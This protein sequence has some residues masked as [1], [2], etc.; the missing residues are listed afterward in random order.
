[1]NAIR[2]STNTAN[3]NERTYQGMQVLKT[4]YKVSLCEMGDRGWGWGRAQ[5]FSSSSAPHHG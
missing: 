2:I 3:Q 1:M 4:A 5:M